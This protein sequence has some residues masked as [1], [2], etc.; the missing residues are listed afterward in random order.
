MSRPSF[1]APILAFFRQG[2]KEIGQVFPATPESIRVVEEPGTLG[3]PT[4]QMVIE[5]VRG[6]PGIL[7]QIDSRKGG[8]GMERE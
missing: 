1:L 6:E 8:P 7:A 4:P 3:N 5:Q 2:T